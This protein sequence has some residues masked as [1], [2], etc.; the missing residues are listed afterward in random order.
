MSAPARLALADRLLSAPGADPTKTPLHL[1]FTIS[2]KLALAQSS[3]PKSF[4]PLQDAYE[5]LQSP[6]GLATG[7]GQLEVE[8]V[9]WEVVRL[10]GELEDSTEGESKGVWELEWERLNN[11]VR[12]TEDVK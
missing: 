8:E 10:L 5:I 9:R 2:L 7:R 4:K 6:G 1:Q 11:R 12:G 3:N